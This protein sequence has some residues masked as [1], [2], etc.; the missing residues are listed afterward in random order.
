MRRLQN[1]PFLHAILLLSL[2]LLGAGGRGIAQINTGALHIVSGTTWVSTPETAVVL[3]NMDL[4]Y[5]ASASWLLNNTFRFTGTTNSA[6]GGNSQ[7][8]VYAVSVVKTSPAKLFLTTQINIAK[9]INFQ[10]GLFDL[11]SL[12]IVLADTALLTNES[13]T[14]RI[15]FA[16]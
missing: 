10:S 6:I 14:S 7:P 2:A 11:N 3:D 1:T 13:E 15:R 9:R 16:V 5:D 12:Y 8:Y 4:Q